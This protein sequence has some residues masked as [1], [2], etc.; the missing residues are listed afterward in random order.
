MRLESYEVREVSEFD[1]DTFESDDKDVNEL[2]KIARN[3]REKHLIRCLENV[4]ECMKNGMDYHFYIDFAKAMVKKGTS[5]KFEDRIARIKELK[6]LLEESKKRTDLIRETLSEMGN[7]EE[8]EDIDEIE[9]DIDNIE[10]VEEVE[11]VEEIEEDI[12][13]EYE[14]FYLLDD[15][16][17]KGIVDFE[18]ENVDNNKLLVRYNLPTGKI[19]DSITD[20]SANYLIGDINKIFLLNKLVS[21]GTYDKDNQALQRDIIRCIEVYYKYKEFVRYY[22]HYNKK[23]IVNNTQFRKHKELLSNLTLSLKSLINYLKNTKV[24]DLDD[25]DD[26]MM[27]KELIAD[28][29]DTGYLRNRIHAETYNISNSGKQIK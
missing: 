10:E 3:T 26:S 7:V 22:Y 14:E 12:D 11:E 1:I 4:Y 19:Y 9:E 24:I 29:I 23:D 28:K 5:R 25:F 21:N 15:D 2:I 13:S 17:D 27:I 8:A 18:T 6:S 16:L 20:I